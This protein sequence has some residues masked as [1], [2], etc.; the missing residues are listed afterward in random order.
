MGLR[1]HWS[2]LTL[3]PGKIRILLASAERG[4]TI[5]SLFGFPVGELGCYPLLPGGGGE[6]GV[7]LGTRPIRQQ[8]N[9]S[10]ITYFHLQ[11]WECVE[12]SLSSHPEMGAVFLLVFD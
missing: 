10:I 8:G 5:C 9:H 11:A 7:G 3:P 4:E 1:A 2:P 6:G 12:D